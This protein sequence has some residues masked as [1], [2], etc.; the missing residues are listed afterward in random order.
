M[1]FVQ[2][3]AFPEDMRGKTFG[4]T[5]ENPDKVDQYVILI[6]DTRSKEVQKLTLKHELS[7]ITLN[8]FHQPWK[9]DDEREAEAESKAIEMTDDEMYL[10]IK[11]AVKIPQEVAG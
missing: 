8:H 6:D 1:I 9:T 3:M 2:Y 4:V 5:I 11:T 7:H 10:L